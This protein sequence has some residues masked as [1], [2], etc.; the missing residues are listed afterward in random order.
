MIVPLAAFLA[1]AL[2]IVGCVGGISNAATGQTIFGN[3]TTGINV[4]PDTTKSVIGTQF[5]V[6]K[7]G[8]VD[9]VKVHRS[10]Q[11]SGALTAKVARGSTVLAT[12]IAPAAGTGWQVVDLPSPVSVV[13]GQTYTVYYTAPAGRYSVKSQ[14]TWPKVSGDLTAVKGVYTFGTGVPTSVYQNES[15]F[16]DVVF[17]PTVVVPPTTSASPSPTTSSEPPVTTSE[18]TTPPVTT[19]VEPTTT[20]PTTPVTSAPPSSGTK[21]GPTNTGVPAGTVLTPYTGPSTITVDGTVID[22]KDVAGSLIIRAKNVVIK[23]SKIHDDMGATA[24]INVQ[25]DASATITDSEIYNFQVG[26]VYANWTG[27]RLNMHDISFDGIKM[28]SNAE[29][30]DSWIHSPKPTSDAHWDGIQ[31]Q[32]GVVNTRIIGNFIDAGDQKTVD[33]NSALFLV[34]D[35]GPGT[36][37]PLTVQNN[38]LNGGN[39]TVYILDGRDGQTIKNIEFTGNR[40]GRSFKYGPTYVNV[41]VTW[42]GN[43]W[44]DTGATIN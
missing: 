31:V 5:R 38:W 10:A 8:T 2:V 43:T 3:T 26:I 14:Y 39:Y 22:G 33:T 25:D 11:V 12:V 37:G 15:Y 13:T 41:P 1:A 19:T 40:F 18:P 36:D 34:P 42:S 16:V 28:S 29:L 44:E 30:R 7:A 20:A 17:N 21:P 35:L 32:N 6:A 24:G 27:I 9:A 4:D 23:N